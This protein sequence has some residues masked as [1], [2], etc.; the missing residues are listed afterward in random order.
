MAGYLACVGLA[1]TDDA[2]SFWRFGKAQ[3]MKPLV[4]Y[5]DGDIA[6]L[7]ILL[8]IIDMEQR[9][10]EIEIG[11][12]VEGQASVTYVAFILRRIVGDSHW[13][14]CTYKKP[15]SRQS[16][17]AT[18]GGDFNA[19]ERPNGGS[20]DSAPRRSGANSTNTSRGAT[21]ASPRMPKTTWP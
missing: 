8:P 6:R 18:G 15:L 1:E 20:L 10:L 9:V 19:I 13:L 12:G 21:S 5:A 3:D 16:A 14:K 11:H 17:V 4:Q 7:A 2:N